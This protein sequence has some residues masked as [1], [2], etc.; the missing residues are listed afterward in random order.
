MKCAGLFLLVLLGTSLCA[1]EKNLPSWEDEDFEPAPVAKTSELVEKDSSPAISAQP[2]KQ[3]AQPKS[4]SKELISLA[5]DWR[6]KEEVEVEKTRI[7]FQN[8][9]KWSKSPFEQAKAYQGLAKTYSASD[10]KEALKLLD[11]AISLAPDMP[12]YYFTAGDKAG[13]SLRD[14]EKALVYF[15]KGYEK[16]RERH[17]HKKTMYFNSLG[18]LY[19]DVEGDLNEAIKYYEMGLK[20]CLNSNPKDAGKFHRL[21]GMVFLELGRCN[22]SCHHLQEALLL[23]D[24]NNFDETI[25]TY[26]TFAKALAALGNYEEAAKIF[27]EGLVY[28]KNQKYSAARD[29]T[30]LT[31]LY[32][33]YASFCFSTS[34]KNKAQR[35]FEEGIA[36]CKDIYSYETSQLY[37]HYGLLLE[38]ARKFGQAKDAYKLGFKHAKKRKPQYSID[39]AVDLARV[40]RLAGN[41]AKALKYKSKA[42]ELVKALA[43]ERETGV[44]KMFGTKT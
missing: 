8:A 37:K 12:D 9:I 15:R 3:A 33:T 28:S 43:P 44:A 16:C 29:R 6:H 42:L 20:Y 4:R 36:T 32:D 31:V 25:I 19:Y 38:E 24:L 5:Q 30:L 23:L 17:E 35:L 41:E 18:T 27:E 10:T 34:Q 7:L 13:F 40:W 2:V 26:V 14:K 21:L 1:M 22:K 11:K 39:L